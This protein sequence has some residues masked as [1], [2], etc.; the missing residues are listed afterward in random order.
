MDRQM[1]NRLGREVLLYSASLSS[2]NIALRTM[3][4]ITGCRHKAEMHAGIAG[5]NEAIEI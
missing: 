2:H 5:E 4:A 3:Y 1:N